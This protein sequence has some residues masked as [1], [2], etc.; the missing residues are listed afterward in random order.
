[1]DMTDLEQEMFRRQ[2]EGMDEET[3]RK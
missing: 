3:I 2:L 1:M